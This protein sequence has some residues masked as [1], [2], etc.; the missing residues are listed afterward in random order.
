MAIRPRIFS[1]AETAYPTDLIS[2]RMLT[3]SYP[4]ITHANDVGA[5]GVD[6]SQGATIPQLSQL[7]STAVAYVRQSQ[8]AH[9]VQSNAVVANPL[10]AASASSSAQAAHSFDSWSWQGFSRSPRSNNSGTAASG[11]TGSSG[12]P[13][14]SPSTGDGGTVSLSG[15]AYVDSNGNHQMDSADWAIACAKI[16]IIPAGSS[17]PLY[18]VSTDWNGAYHFDGLAAGTYAVEI[19]TP[20]SVP[21]ADNGDARLVMNGSNVVSVGTMGTS[22][23]NAWSNVTLSDGDAGTYFDFCR[24]VLSR[25]CPLERTLVNS[26]PGILH[27]NNIPTL[28]VPIPEPSSLVLLAIAAALF[29]SRMWR[30]RATSIRS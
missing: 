9:A 3:S 16:A 12:L 26:S 10:V 18:V 23:D 8:A 25:R 28:V 15:F 21:G 27:T 13:N 29:G 1:F 14:G 7:A 11:Q 24:D 22:G 20:S 5:A 17:T 19:L 2:P 6:Q 4:G 30:R